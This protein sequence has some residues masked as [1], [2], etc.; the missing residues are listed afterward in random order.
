MDFDF[1]REMLAFEEKI[2]LAKLEETKAAQ[3]VK[4]LEYHKSRYSLE[5]FLASASKQ[6]QA[7]VG[8]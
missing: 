2:A 1:Q 8:K 5:Y 3:R 6:Q 7:Q 4:E